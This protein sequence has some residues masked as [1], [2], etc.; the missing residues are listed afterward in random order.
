MKPKPLH[1]N[2]AD[3]APILEI[4]PHLSVSKTVFVRLVRTVLE[5]L[6]EDDGLELEDEEVL[7]E[8]YSAVFSLGGCGPAEDLI[9]QARRRAKNPTDPEEDVNQTYK[10][11]MTGLSETDTRTTEGYSYVYSKYS[12]NDVILGH[13]YRKKRKRSDY[14]Q[15]TSD[16]FC[17]ASMMHNGDDRK[18]RKR[19][20]DDDTQADSIGSDDGCRRADE[21]THVGDSSRKRW[22]WLKMLIG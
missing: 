9:Q 13:V 20:E 14:A 11:V 21:S 6:D 22:S 18:K 12:E 8:M 3:G 15:T 10:W 16:G 1:T 5:E 2:P 7:D 19:P 17:H 4:P